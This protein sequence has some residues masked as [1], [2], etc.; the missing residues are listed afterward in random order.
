MT[1]IDETAVAPTYPIDGSA[2]RVT[3]ITCAYL[4]HNQVPVSQ[5]GEVIAAIT[6][7][8]TGT[9]TRTK[10]RGE[11]AVPIKKSLGE[12]FIICLEDGKRLTMLKRYLRSQYDMSPEEYRAK[13]NLPASY[14]MVCPA[15]AKLRSAFAKKIGLGRIPV[16]K[17]KPRA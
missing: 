17:K 13:W 9:G 14:P 2:E 6:A 5:I 8:I 15:Y 11:P 7:A 12:D 3:R 16:S 4:S 1:A 10:P